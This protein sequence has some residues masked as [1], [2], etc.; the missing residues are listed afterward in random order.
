MARHHR[1]FTFFSIV[2]LV[3]LDLKKKYCLCWLL[4]FMLF[5]VR[6]KRCSGWKKMRNKLADQPAEQARILYSV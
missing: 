6:E 2:E 1:T 3:L 5:S 4:L